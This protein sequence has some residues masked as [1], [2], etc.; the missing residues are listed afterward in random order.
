MIIIYM[1]FFKKKIINNIHETQFS[2][3]TYIINRE[4]FYKYL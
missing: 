2:V 4:Y 1:V 3:H